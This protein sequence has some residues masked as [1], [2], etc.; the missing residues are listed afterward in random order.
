VKIRAVGELA[1]LSTKSPPGRHPRGR[2]RPRRRRSH[3]FRCTRAQDASHDSPQRR[4]VD[5]HAPSGF[6]G[7]DVHFQHGAI[8]LLRHGQLHQ[9]SV[10]C[11]ALS[12]ARVTHPA[13]YDTRASV[14]SSLMTWVT[15]ASRDVGTRQGRRSP[16]GW[17]RAFGGRGLCV[18]RL[19]LV[20]GDANAGDVVGPD[21]FSNRGDHGR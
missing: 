1:R 21:E 12:G 18:L 6:F 19:G 4:S 20:A 15:E 10:E 16:C 5:G 9:H 13:E 8:A 14:V 11:H 2:R 17:R 3:P 7:G